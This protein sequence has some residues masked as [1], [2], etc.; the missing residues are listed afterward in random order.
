MRG[1]GG[2]DRAAAG[3]PSDEEYVARYC[4]RRGIE[5]PRNWDFY[6]AFCFFRL[7]AILQGV[8]KRA[9]DGNAS[10]PERA[11]RVGKAVP[12]L[13]GMGLERT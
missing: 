9:Q 3:L 7:A 6:V 1:L 4:E 8:W 2:V 5:P 11:N 12:V 13:V 10:N